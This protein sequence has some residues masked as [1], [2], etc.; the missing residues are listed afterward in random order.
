M[1]PAGT[2]GYEQLVDTIQREQGF[3]RRRGAHGQ[4]TRIEI[5][6]IRA[7]ADVRTTVSSIFAPALHKTHQMQV[8]LRN[9]PN[10]V[11][12][13]Q[14]KEIVDKTSLGDYDFMYLRIGTYL[15][16]TYSTLPQLTSL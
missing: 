16:L 8:M 9:I 4:Y 14:L 7:G 11:T 5:G 3:G 10:R 2:P 6:R 12:Q 15:M 13:A 1:V